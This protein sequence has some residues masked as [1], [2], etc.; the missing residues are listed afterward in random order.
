M[1]HLPL[2]GSAF[3]PLQLDACFNVARSR[4]ILAVKRAEARAPLTMFLL[5]L[6]SIVP[7]ADL[8]S[9]GADR[10]AIERV[11]YNHR[12]GDKPPFEQTMPPAL[13]E[14]L[15]RE[16][17]H[18]EAVLKKSYGV[19]ITPAMLAAEVQRIN[20]TTRAPEV[21]AELK[22]A[23]GNDT[24]RFAR[25]VARPIVV[26]RRLREK[27][28]SDDALHAPQRRETEK[29]R[30]QLLA[31]RSSRG[32]EAQ[33]SSPQPST[34]NSQPHGRSLLPPSQSYDVT[35]TSAA[36]NDLNV[37]L[38]ASLENGHSN[39]VTETTWQLGARPVATNAPSADEIDIKQRFGPDAQILS[40]PQ[41]EKDR[42]FYFEDLPAELQNVLRVQLRQP[43]D[44][45]AVIETPSGFLL[46]V[47]KAKT[48]TVLSVATLSL[49]K[50]NY[51][52]WLAEQPNK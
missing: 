48:E 34:L 19:E 35:S 7:A 30:E 6:C 13:V 9:L 14:K 2:R 25:T 8:A 32:N 37:K 11:Y 46:Y 51:E 33:T 52:Q 17:L 22:A 40:P 15:V 45:S 47:A 24:N 43:G 18:K 36:A 31:V 20:A 29:V 49:P 1:L 10:A 4:R 44:V 28:D 5:L 21:L 16:D 3:R 42:K 38:V 39:D 50:R 12:L 26:E 41:T 23:L 27:F